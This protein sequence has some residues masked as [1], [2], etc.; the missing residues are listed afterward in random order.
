MYISTYI[1]INWSFQKYVYTNLI[2]N[3]SI[4]FSK[5]FISN[6]LSRRIK[7]N[8]NIIAW[9]NSLINDDTTS[10]NCTFFFEFYISVMSILHKKK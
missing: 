7:L 2:Q 9:K 1:Y 8:T 6:L 4:H 10:S 5:Q 3:Y